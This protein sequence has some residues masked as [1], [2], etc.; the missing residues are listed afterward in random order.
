MNTPSDKSTEFW[1]LIEQNRPQE[2]FKYFIEKIKDTPCS[3]LPKLQ[4]TM[5]DTLS[6]RILPELREQ[7]TLWMVRH[8]DLMRRMLRLLTEALELNYLRATT[9]D[10]IAWL[11]CLLAIE[12]ALAGRVNR[13]H[14]ELCLVYDGYQ[15]DALPEPNGQLHQDI[16][17]IE[18]TERTTVEFLKHF[19]SSYMQFL[20]RNGQH[21]LANHLDSRVS[22]LLGLIARDEKRPGVVQALFYDK[23]RAEGH[24][25][26]VHIS[27]ERLSISKQQHPSTE[28]IE[29][30]RNKKDIDIAM[31]EAAVYTQQVVDAYLKRSGYPDGLD[32]R[33]IRW[34]IATVEG[35]AVELEQEC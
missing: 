16:K 27:L 28:V 24:G 21:D 20:H 3:K 12:E 33:F 18:L 22:R 15:T 29:Y 8:P 34:E 11:R 5:L 14:E 19:F 6:R 26:F 32:E 2:A 30:A 31:Q 4:K 23:T 35:D 7:Y 13:V 25:R 1:E 10:N 17:N 9:I